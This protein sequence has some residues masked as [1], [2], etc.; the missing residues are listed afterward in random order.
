MA[1]L[2]LDQ[3]ADSGHEASVRQQEVI[4]REDRLRL[5]LGLLTALKEPLGAAWWHAH[6]QESGAAGAIGLNRGRSGRSRYREG[7]RGLCCGMAARC[8]VSLCWVDLVAFLVL[9]Q[10]Q[11][12]GT[13]LEWE[14]EQ[15][16]LLGRRLVLALSALLGHVLGV[17]HGQVL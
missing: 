13:P 11:R 6:A 8:C 7:C 16:L 5:L 10:G 9:W 4:L 12:T 3:A 17:N 1:L 2:L 14:L 15:L